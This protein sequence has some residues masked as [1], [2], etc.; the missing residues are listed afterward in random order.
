[1]ANPN[2]FPHHHADKPELTPVT[3]SGRGDFSSGW[4]NNPEY[5]SELPDGASRRI[6]RE[7]LDKMQQFLDG[8]STKSNEPS[9]SE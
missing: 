9:E 8:A 7:T 5:A 6:G 1:M 2:I 4:E 3:F